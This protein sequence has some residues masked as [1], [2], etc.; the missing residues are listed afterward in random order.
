L[1]DA[2][3]SRRT[4]W[5]WYG[6]Q[7]LFVD[8]VSI[9]AILLGAATRANRDRDGMSG[10]LLGVGSTGVVFGAPIVHWVHGHVGKGFGSLGLMVVPPLVALGMLIDGMGGL[11]FGDSNTPTHHSKSDAETFVGAAILIAWIP[12]AVAVDAACLAYEEVPARERPSVAW[13]PRVSLVR[14][15]GTLGAGGTF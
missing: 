7:T 2:P 10:S 13:A 1:V 11:D 15:G 5:R 3:P 8:G 6:A 9:A 14:G 4:E 12:T